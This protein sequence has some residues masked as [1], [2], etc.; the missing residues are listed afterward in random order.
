MPRQCRENLRKYQILH[1]K[2]MPDKI[3]LQHF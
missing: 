2:G 1:K 3:I